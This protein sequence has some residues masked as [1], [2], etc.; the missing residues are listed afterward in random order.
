MA[1]RKA[2]AAKHGG[3]SFFA[4]P[5]VMVKSDSFA[6]L[7]PH[8]LKL[9]F[10]L[11]ASY[12]GFNN[13]DLSA[14]W[15]LMERRGWRSRDTLGKALHQLLDGG[16]IVKTRQGGLHRCSLYAVTF[17]A[18]DDVHDKTGYSKFDA[19]ISATASPPGGWFRDAPSAVVRLPA[20]AF[21]RKP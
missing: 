7:S 4:I 17:Y 2:R 8:A 14:A 16:W 12:T 9:L 18:V 1:R 11:L 19:G 21:D 3:G 6:R 15:K 10:D 20:R 5:R 13:G